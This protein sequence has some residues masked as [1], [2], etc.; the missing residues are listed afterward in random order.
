MPAFFFYHILLWSV[1]CG[2]AWLFFSLLASSQRISSCQFISHSQ[3]RQGGGLDFQ[4][5]KQIV[6]NRD[7]H[8]P[9]ASKESI[10]EV[11]GDYSTRRWCNVVCLASPI[12][13]EYITQ[14]T[15]HTVMETQANMVPETQPDHLKENN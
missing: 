13:L 10:L 4:K 3:P 11:V 14:H 6:V 7:H 12:H 1:R 9:S 5:S 8:F 15:V 2:W